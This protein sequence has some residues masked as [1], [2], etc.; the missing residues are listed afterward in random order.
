MVL[1]IETKQDM[2]VC[3]FNTGD[4]YRA[5]NFNPA[6]NFETACELDYSKAVSLLVAEL[7]KYYHLEV[8]GNRR[9]CHQII[10]EVILDWLAS[11]YQQDLEGYKNLLT[12]EISHILFSRTELT[13]PMHGI[14]E[15][16]NDLIEAMGK[17]GNFDDS[18]IPASIYRYVVTRLGNDFLNLVSP[19]SFNWLDSSIDFTVLDTEIWGTYAMRRKVID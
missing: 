3:L 5:L 1:S 4:A 17:S 6:L 7:V 2:Y 11:Y 12:K 16:I 8:L 15:E 14:C 10:K 13:L 18:R 9:E 19:Y